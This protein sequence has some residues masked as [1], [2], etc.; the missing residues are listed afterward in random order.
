MYQSWFLRHGHMY[1][2][3]KEYTGTLHYLCNFC[4]S[5]IIQNISDDFIDNI[6]YYNSNNKYQKIMLNLEENIKQSVL[7]AL[8]ETFEIF[9]NL[10]LNS[11]DR[12]KIFNVCI[13]KCHRNIV[14]IFSILEFD[15]IY[16]YDKKDR[17]KHFFF[18]DNF[19]IT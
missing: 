5:K 12:K 8:I 2:M 18:I 13:R 3:D 1:K 17:N 7:K 11:N 9:H 19:I 14:T 15:R 10:Y 16:Y 6:F 4:I